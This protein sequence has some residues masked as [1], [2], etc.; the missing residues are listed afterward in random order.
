MEHKRT[1]LVSFIRKRN[2]QKFYVADVS[3]DGYFRK[4]VNKAFRDRFRKPEK[5]AKSDGV[6]IIVSRVSDGLIILRRKVYNKSALQ[7]M[8]ELEKM[9]EATPV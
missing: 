1:H 6:N 8:T 3:D 9:I 4:V 7:T 2:K 5:L